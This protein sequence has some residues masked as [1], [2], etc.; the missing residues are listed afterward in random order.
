VNDDIMRKAKRECQRDWYDEILKY[1]RA[2]D[3]AEAV[4]YGNAAGVINS[5]PPEEVRDFTLFVCIQA[6][7]ELDRIAWQVRENM[8]DILARDTPSEN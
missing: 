8:L 5:I 1:L 7:A 2:E 3:V 4:R 6:A